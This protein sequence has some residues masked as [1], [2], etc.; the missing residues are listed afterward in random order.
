MS[1]KKNGFSY[2]I[3]FVYAIGVG[4]ALVDLGVMVCKG[5]GLEAYAGI[6]AAAV[7]AAVAAG[8]A[9]LLH[10]IAAG[11][12]S[13]L[14]EKRVHLTVLGA[15]A[16]V[17]LFA[18]GIFLRLQAFGGSE[19]SLEYY[20]AAKVVEGQRIPQAVHGAVY[21]YT[22][23]L[24]GVFVLVGNY[25]SAGIWLQIGLQ[26]ASVFFLFLI[27]RRLAGQIAALVVLGFCMCAPFMVTSS[28]RMSPDML[29][30]FLLTAAVQ[31]LTVGVTAERP[32]EAEKLPG[33]VSFVASLFAGILAAVCLYLDVSGVLLLILAVGIILCRRREAESVGEKAF[34]LFSCMAGVVS[35]FAA[36]LF[37][38]AFSSGKSAYRVA[39]AWMALYRPEAFRIPASVSLSG[40]SAEGFL[41]FGLMALGLFSFWFDK[42][43]ERMSVCVLA[44]GGIIAGSC[45]GIFTEEMPGYLY[46]YLLFAVLA[47]IGL[48]QCFAVTPAESEAE[49]PV[50]KEKPDW[51]ILID[52]MEE[53]EEAEK[54]LPEAEGAEKR[55]HFIENPLPLPKKHV[56]RVLD[57]SLPAAGSEDDFDYQVS[58]DDDFDI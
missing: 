27:V 58:E 4:V 3:W 20:E 2:L 51:E 28:L 25:A 55:I 31:L 6:A 38:D 15:L 40:S 32:G 23:L 9:L 21:F 34:A 30:L 48:G 19:Y 17:A 14:T 42:K 47:G 13:F 37:L 56:K 49:E 16:A 57:Y 18:V 35:G 54:T 1:W 33:K 53:R 12:I 26:L 50:K 46:L 36:C 22:L 29:Y 7:S 52:S 45:Y 10:R 24:H 5:A 39:A 44:A 43:K 8:I 41:L 11:R